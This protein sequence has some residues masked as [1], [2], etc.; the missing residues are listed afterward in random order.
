MIFTS[1]LFF[2]LRFRRLCATLFVFLVSF[3]YLIDSNC[4]ISFDPV[5]IQSMTLTSSTLQIRRHGYS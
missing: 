3:K 1:I 2:I 5:Q 4:P